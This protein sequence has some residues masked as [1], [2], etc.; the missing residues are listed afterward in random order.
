MEDDENKSLNERVREREEPGHKLA[1][2][3]LM[4]V[5]IE[6]VARPFF[7]EAYVLFFPVPVCYLHSTFFSL[8]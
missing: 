5:V 6:I 1:M 2:L 7:C 8:A 3:I 4:L